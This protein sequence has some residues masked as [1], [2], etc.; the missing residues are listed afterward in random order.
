[1]CSAIMIEYLSCFASRKPAAC[2]LSCRKARN[3]T[4]AFPPDWMSCSGSV[5]EV[6]FF[7]RREWCAERC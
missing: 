6:F 1:M 4:F 2:E 3:V 5:V 7:K